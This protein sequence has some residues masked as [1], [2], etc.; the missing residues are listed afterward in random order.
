LTTPVPQRVRGDVAGRTVTTPG[1]ATCAGPTLP[2]PI[3]LGTLPISTVDLRNLRVSTQADLRI[4]RKFLILRPVDLA[5]FSISTQV[6]RRVAEFPHFD[7]GGS[8]GLAKIP[9]KTT[10]PPKHQAAPRAAQPQ[11]RS[12]SGS[13]PSRVGCR[14]G[15]ASRRWAS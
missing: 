15:R 11:P 2:G 6:S 13:M 1:V 4:L 14:Q 3:V 12:P 9:R 8:G 10:S 7:A 5:N